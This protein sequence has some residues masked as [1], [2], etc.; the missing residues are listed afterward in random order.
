MGYEGFSEGFRGVS[1]GYEGFSELFEKSSE[2]QKLSIWVL[3][4]NSA[5]SALILMRCKDFRVARNSYLRQIGKAVANQ[6]YFR[7]ILR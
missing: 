6:E 1:R 5:N 4:G 7:I 3:G 2:P